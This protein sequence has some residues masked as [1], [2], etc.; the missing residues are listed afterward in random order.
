MNA[1]AV[2]MLS[3][4]SILSACASTRPAP[5][6]AGGRI[7]IKPRPPVTT[8]SAPIPTPPDFTLTPAR[9]AEIPGWAAADMAPALAAF[10]RDE[11][12]LLPHLRFSSSGP[13]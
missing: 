8:P 4:A 9:F 6:I 2:L 11:P 12:A 5:V 10:K 7:P 13:C 3:L 1:R